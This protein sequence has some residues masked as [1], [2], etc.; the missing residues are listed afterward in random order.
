MSPPPLT[1]EEIQ[2]DLYTFLEQNTGPA[3]VDLVEPF[4]RAS[5]LPPITHESLSELDIGRIVN[6]PKLRHDVNFDKELHFRPNLDGSR[7]KSKLRAADEYWK[8]LIGEL[9]LYR[10]VGQQLLTCGSERQQYWMRM[11]QASQ[12]RMPGMFATIRDVLKTLVPERDQQTVSEKLD[13]PMIMQQISKG[14]F[15]LMDLA[16]WLAKLLKAHCAP[17][18]DDWIDQMVGQTQKG[19]NEG[20]QKRIVIGLRQLLSILEAMKLDVAN[21]QI[22]HLRGLLIEDAIS[23]QQRYHMH[24]LSFGRMDIS[25]A[26][27]WFQR[28]CLQIMTPH[29]Q[30]DKVNVMAS[31][32]LRILL[33]HQ[34][35]SSFPETFHLDADRLRSMR[36]DLHYLIHLDICCEVFDVLCGP[37]VVEGVRRAA[38]ESL[39][40][41][42]A[43]IVGESGRFIDSAGNIAVEIVRLVLEL[44]GSSSRSNT[45]IVDL[46]EQRLKVDLHLSSMAFN[47]RT[48]ALLDNQLPSLYNSIMSNIKLTPMALHEVMVPYQAGTTLS[49]TTKETKTPRETPTMENVIRRIAHVSTLHWHIWSPIVYMTQEDEQRQAEEERE[50]ESEASATSSDTESDQI[51]VGVHSAA[52]SPSPSPSPTPESA[53]AYSNHAS[54]PSMLSE[55]PSE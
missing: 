49:G 42:L 40:D 38:K 8:A 25:R 21:H 51:S 34:S 28:E 53:T 43:D 23:F 16:H 13:V 45:D 4:D 26:R 5:E 3:N 1:D 47:S 15:D 46:A 9:E 14:V 52:P 39:K 18:R 6:N 7:G 54:G 29:G 19:V 30:V 31:G 10:A 12:K 2:Y 37:S 36:S 20:C 22:R 11:M 17:M 41:S 44:E 32:T 35:V 33:S 27:R 48:R 50:M 24:R 55:P